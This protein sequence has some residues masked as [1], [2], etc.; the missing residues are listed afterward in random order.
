MMFLVRETGGNGREEVKGRDIRG[1]EE[2][3]RYVEKI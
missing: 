2:E 1:K 3:R